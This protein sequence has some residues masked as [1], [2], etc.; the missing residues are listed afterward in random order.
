MQP[1]VLLGLLLHTWSSRVNG[2][3]TWSSFRVSSS[4]C[5]WA[6]LAVDVMV[7]LRAAYAR[8]SVLSL[9][10]PCPASPR[11]AVCSHPPSRPQ[12][13]LGENREAPHLAWLGPGV[14]G[15]RGEAEP[16]QKGLQSQ[17]GGRVPGS[18]Q[19]D[20]VQRHQDRGGGASPVLAWP[21]CS[22]P[23][24]PGETL[25]WSAHWLSLVAPHPPLLHT[26]E[27]EGPT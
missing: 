3:C 22:G 12:V 5:L 25:V 27:G 2:Y 10:T 15:A 8:G 26:V 9:Y 23:R 7:I 18:R 4:F 14:E 24:C 1:V 13:P 6:M 20:E 19:V 17:W 21:P 16:I 11:P